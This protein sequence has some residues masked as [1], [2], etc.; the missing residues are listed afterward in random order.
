MISELAAA[1]VRGDLNQVEFLQYC[2]GLMLAGFETT[3]TIIGQAMRMQL[4]NSV[5]KEAHE[6]CMQKGEVDALIEEY[7]RMVTPAM[8]FARTATA[9]MSFHGQEIKQHDVMVMSY[10]AANRDP[11]TFENPH[12]FRPARPNAAEHMAF[13]NGFHRC[14]GAALA[15]LEMRILFEQ[16]HNRGLRFELTGVPDPGWSSFINQ[17]RALPVRVVNV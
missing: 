10:A 4:E 2:R 14:V 15:K 16:I 11:A 8:H 13:G 1:V 6:R 3:H 9:D 12:D 5:V 17:I 7:L